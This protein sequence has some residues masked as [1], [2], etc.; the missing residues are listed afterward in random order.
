MTENKLADGE[1]REQRR[2]CLCKLTKFVGAAGVAAAVWPLVS[3][4]GPDEKTLAENEPIDISLAGVA[5]GQT[6]RRVWQGKLILI[7]HRTQMRL[8]LPEVPTGIRLSTH[9]R[10]ARG[11]Q[12]LILNGW[13]FKGIAHMPGAYPTPDREGWV[14]SVRA[15]A[16]SLIPPGA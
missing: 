14:G 2:E 16:Q 3:A 6:V 4:P 1:I 12:Q 11:S 10:T 5:A 15:T 7:H 9:N 13:W 8:L